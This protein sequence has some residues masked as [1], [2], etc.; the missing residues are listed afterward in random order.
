V[1]FNLVEK[2]LMSFT[3]LKDKEMGVAKVVVARTNPKSAD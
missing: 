1:N 3:S 2:A